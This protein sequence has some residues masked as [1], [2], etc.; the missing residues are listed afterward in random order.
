MNTRTTGLRTVILVVG[1]LM[2]YVAV[3]AI[4]AEL[5]RSRRYDGEIKLLRRLAASDDLSL[6]EALDRSVV[7]VP[8]GNFLMGSNTGRDDERPQRLV[9]LDAFEIDRYEVTNA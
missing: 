7:Y 2:A 8:A 3:R 6:A 4:W 9:Y 1:L 5:N